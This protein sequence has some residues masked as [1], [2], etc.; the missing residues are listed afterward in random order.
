[1]T[2]LNR[3]SPGKNHFR[4]KNAVETLNSFP[5][6]IDITNRKIRAFCKILLMERTLV[7]RKS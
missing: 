4:R 5:I 7:W 2:V 6:Y 1:M 3:P